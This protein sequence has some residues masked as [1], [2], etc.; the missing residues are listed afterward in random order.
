MREW[1]TSLT[2]QAR[3]NSL[4]QQAV[5]WW[6]SHTGN[7]VREFQE[8]LDISVELLEGGRDGVLVNLRAPGP[9]KGRTS[10]N[11]PLIEFYEA[12]RGLASGEL[13]RAQFYQ[14][15]WEHPNSTTPNGWSES[16]GE[17]FF[18]PKDLV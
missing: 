3:R 18:L 12:A 1:F 10:I 6:N 5:E 13:T 4:N 15:T 16:K 17:P 2:V 14:K 7:I 9:Y 8:R 11:L